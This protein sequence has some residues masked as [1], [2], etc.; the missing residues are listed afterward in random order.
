[1]SRGKLVLNSYQKP[2][3]VPLVSNYG[4]CALATLVALERLTGFSHSDI[5][6]KVSKTTIYT[7]TCSRGAHGQDACS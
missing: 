1:M 7:Q 2:R 5:M 3:T 4:H 6:V